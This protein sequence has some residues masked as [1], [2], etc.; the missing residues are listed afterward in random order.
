SDSSPTLFFDGCC[1]FCNW[2]V[3][4]VWRLDRTGVIRFAPIDSGLG[5]RMLERYPELSSID[6]AFLTY[7]KN[8]EER[9]ASRS[10]VFA[11]L[12]DLIAGRESSRCF[13]SRLFLG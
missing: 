11:Q 2:A 6:S 10:G 4:V 12:A 13:H 5:R 9:Y 1:P 8:G 7:S 3:R